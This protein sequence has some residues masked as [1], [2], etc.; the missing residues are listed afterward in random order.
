M[1][2]PACSFGHLFVEFWGSLTAITIFDSH[3]GYAAVC[4]G[5]IK[6]GLHGAV[7]SG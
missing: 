6:S 1:L 3:S 2:A 4:T 5:K 7:W